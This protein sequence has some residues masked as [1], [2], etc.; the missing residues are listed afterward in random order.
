[1]GEILRC[2]GGRCWRDQLIDCATLKHCTDEER[3]LGN[4]GATANGTQHR[5]FF[6]RTIKTWKANDESIPRNHAPGADDTDPP[7]GNIASPHIDCRSGLSPDDCKNPQPAADA[8][9]RVL[10][11]AGDARFSVAAKRVDGLAK[12]IGRQF[13]AFARGRQTFFTLPVKRSEAAF[14]VIGRF[15]PEDKRAVMGTKQTPINRQAEGEELCSGR[16]PF[17][18]SGMRWPRRTH[19]E[20][21]EPSTFGS[22]GRRSIQLS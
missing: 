5:D 16:V 14:H 7:A 22:V 9:A 18:N 17:G 11:L 2:G 13:H 15:G 6:V 12:Q 3:I 10:A 8:D 4:F 19:L 1:M 20:G 21:L